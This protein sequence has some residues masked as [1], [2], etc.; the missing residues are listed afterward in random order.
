MG[1]TLPPFTEFET[2]YRTE[3]N[4]LGIFKKIV[5]TIP[6]RI[7]F[8]YTEGPDTYYTNP[9]T[10]AIG[11]Y[12]VTEFPKEDPQFA[13]W[14]LKTKPEGARSNIKRKEP[15]WRVDN[16]KVEEIHQGALDMGYI[17]NFK[18]WKMCHIYKYPDATIVFYTVIKDGT[19]KEDHF[20]EIEVDE[21]SIYMLTEDEAWA[22][23]EKYEKILAET[24]IIPQKRLRKSL[25]EM[26]MEEV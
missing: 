14:T 12:R 5:K 16:T 26:Y 13:Q 11:R 4:I 8:L 15:N 3:L 18:I 10:K 25:A 21:D 22:V 24:G 2:K 20:I 7:Y 9:N 6:N 1:E 23:I 19:D 17:F